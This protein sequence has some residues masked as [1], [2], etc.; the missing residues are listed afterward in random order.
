MTAFQKIVL[1]LLVAIYNNTRAENSGYLFL[2]AFYD[3]YDHKTGEK[4]I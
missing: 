1:R 4:W 2:D 3:V